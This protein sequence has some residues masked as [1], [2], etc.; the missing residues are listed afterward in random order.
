MWRVLVVSCSCATHHAVKRALVGTEIGGCS[1]EL[2]HANDSTA[3]LAVLRRETNI[4]VTIID[5]IE[6]VLDV[7]SAGGPLV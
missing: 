6:E 4:A 1:L 7:E 3:A 5:C 2:L